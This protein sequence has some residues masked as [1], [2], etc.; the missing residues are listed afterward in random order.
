MTSLRTF[1]R[2]LIRPAARTRTEE[3]GLQTTESSFQVV[4]LDL[5]LAPNDP[6]AAYL[7][8]ADGVVDVASLR[9]DSP[10]LHSLHQAGARVVVPLISQG[11]LV[12]LIALGARLSEQDYSA[13]DRK[14]LA[15]LATQAA[16]AVR[17]AQLVSQQQREALERVRVDQELRIAG[18]IQQSLLPKGVPELPGWEVAVY[19]QPAREVGGD[20][21]EFLKY[22]DGR[23]GFIV[24]DVTDKGVPAA[25]VMA[26]TRSLLRAVT[27]RLSAP[28]AVLERVNELLH[29]DIPERMFV[30]CFYALLDPATG[31][32]HYA[33]AGHDLPYRRG[34]DGVSELR[35]TGMPLGLMPD[36]HYEE[37]ELQLEP[38]DAVLFH[39]DG[40]AEAHD[41][42]REMFGFPRLKSLVA[43][44]TSPEG[45]IPLVLERLAAFTGPG[46]ER[47]DDVTL[48]SLHRSA[49]PVSAG[50]DVEGKPEAVSADERLLAAFTVA[51]EPGNE[52]G[53]AEQV[54]EAVHELGLPAKR[55][56]KLRTA[57]AEATMNAMEHGNGYE[58]DKPVAVQVSSSSEAVS[59]RITD[60]GGDTPVAEAE[61]PDLEA[62]LAGE[63]SPR[64][65]GLFLIRSMVDDMKVSTGEDA[66]GRATHTVEL[67]LQLGVEQGGADVG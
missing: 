29:P 67:I 13:D 38:G 5:E 40:V 46:W 58:P 1:W 33:N 60:L 39:S 64:G 2:N 27:E 9:L 54:A 21:Y 12:G 41:P 30:T 45:L 23:I 66:D 37:F 56:D 51:S 15:D 10:G 34:A 61:T 7:Q 26:T 63:Q 43:E 8:S 48:V 57:V 44:V 47:E 20:F 53:V 24:G 16:P 62:K 36:M 28:G 18:V 49:A 19:Y 42:E 55:L 50:D 32:V 31:L 6:L 25:M 52:R 65:W 59:V 11:E 35:A 17:V 3:P 14:L 4:D 22:D